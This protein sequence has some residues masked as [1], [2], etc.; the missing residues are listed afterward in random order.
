MAD[1]VT[2][3]SD[4]IDQA[5]AILQHSLALKVAEIRRDSRR[6]GLSDADFGGLIMP[7]LSAMWTKPAATAGLLSAALLCLAD[8]QRLA[9]KGSATV[10]MLRASLKRGDA[11][12]V[13]DLDGLDGLF[14]TIAFIGDDVIGGDED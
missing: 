9:E 13:H 3:Q 6:E 7:E 11:I 4:E 1:P 2:R 10:A 8:T 12:D 14:C 5:W